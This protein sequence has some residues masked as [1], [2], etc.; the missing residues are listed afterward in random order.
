V[1]VPLVVDVTVEIKDLP[2]AVELGNGLLVYPRFTAQATGPAIPYDVSIEGHFQAG[3]FRVLKLTAISR[4]NGESVSTEGL[5]KVP[6]GRIMRQALEKI[7][8]DWE[9]TSGLVEWGPWGVRLHTQPK[10]PDEDALRTV[11]ALYR[12]AHM[13]GVPP[14]AYVAETLNLPKSTAGRWVG[15]ARRSGHLGPALGTKAGEASK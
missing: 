4:A 15:L 6:V 1:P 5:R 2:A 10:G 12:F 14:T 11:A 7:V 13:V 8:V 3:R 9:W